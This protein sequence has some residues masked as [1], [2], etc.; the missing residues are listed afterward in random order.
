MMLALPAEASVTGTGAVG[1]GLGV[2][3]KVVFRMLVTV[4]QS[5]Q[6]QGLCEGTT[7]TDDLLGGVL[8]QVHR[9]V[10]QV[11]R[12]D[13]RGSRSEVGEPCIEVRGVKNGL[14]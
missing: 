1:A 8:R 6:A 3:V 9:P 11:G 12:V 10:A 4:S 7:G 14:V 13:G 2:E 5:L